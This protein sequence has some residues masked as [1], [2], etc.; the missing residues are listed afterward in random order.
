M[1]KQE[2]PEKT[3]GICL[4]ATD[5]QTAKERDIDTERQRGENRLAGARV[6]SKGRRGTARYSEG[7]RC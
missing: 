6:P 3:R 2:I 7:G 5:R 4:C 1:A